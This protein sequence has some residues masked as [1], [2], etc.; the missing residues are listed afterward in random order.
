MSEVTPPDLP[1]HV[2]RLAP[3]IAAGLSNAEIARALGLSQHTTENYVSALM[4]HAGARHRGALVIWA[5]AR[6]R[7]PRQ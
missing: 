4:Q 5:Q 3:L 1:D 2:A 7:E 6:A